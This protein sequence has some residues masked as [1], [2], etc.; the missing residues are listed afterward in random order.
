MGT[1]E[2]LQLISQEEL[3]QVFIDE[4][5][6]YHICWQAERSY[7]GCHSLHVTL[8]IELINTRLKYSSVVGLFKDGDRIYLSGQHASFSFL[9]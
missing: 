2:C 5:L 4:L 7:Y 9:S 6:S 8:I 1:P 3:H